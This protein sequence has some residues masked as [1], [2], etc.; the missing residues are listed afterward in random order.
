MAVAAELAQL[1]AQL[2][3][4]GAQLAGA[5]YAPQDRAQP[6]DVHRLHHV[7]G[8]AEAQRLHGALDARMAGDQH[9]LGGFLRLE[10]VD[11]LDA[12]AVGQLQ[13]GEQHIGLQARHVD[14]CSTQAIRLRYCEAFAFRELRKP[15]QRFGVVVYKQQMGHDALRWRSCMDGCRHQPQNAYQ[16]ARKNFVCALKQLARACNVALSPHGVSRAVFFS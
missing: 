5:R 4:L 6:L 7:V 8:G 2:A 10:V 14:A 12:L 1:L 11:Q 3:D 15:F 9:H 16:R 13:I